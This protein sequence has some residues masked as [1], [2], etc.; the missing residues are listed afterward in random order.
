MLAGI[1]AGG[2]V[3][4]YSYPPSARAKSGHAVSGTVPARTASSNALRASSEVAARSATMGHAAADVEPLLFRANSIK[5][6]TPAP[7]GRFPR[8][9]AA[10]DF[11]LSPAA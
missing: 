11:H 8:A 2:A 10:Y 7:S 1:V 5:A 9:M 3:M 6:G 4:W